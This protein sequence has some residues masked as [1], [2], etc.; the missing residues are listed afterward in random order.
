MWYVFK[1]ERERERE[2]ERDWEIERECRTTMSMHLRMIHTMTP[3]EFI[4]LWKKFSLKNGCT[5]IVSTVLNNPDRSKE[6]S[7][8]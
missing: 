5:S 7:L 3:I 2:R 8:W 6:L 1:R 4:V